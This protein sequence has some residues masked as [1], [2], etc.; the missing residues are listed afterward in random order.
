MTTEN[1]SDNLG[2]KEM[3]KRKEHPKKEVEQALRHAEQ[4]GW[5][6]E[7][8]RAHWGVMFCPTN[9]GICG[10]KDHCMTAIAGTPASPQNHAKKLR[11]Y[12]D[13]CAAAQQAAAEA[14]ANGDDDE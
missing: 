8:G 3:G 14:R 2:V 7:S 10:C 11:S 4:H 6:V 13:R 12:V 5:R 9:D 1:E